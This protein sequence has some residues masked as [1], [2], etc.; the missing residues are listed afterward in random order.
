M[1]GCS[2]AVHASRTRDTS[3]LILL[4][5]Q[6]QCKQKGD[7]WAFRLLALVTMTGETLKGMIEMAKAKQRA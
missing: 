5:H 2:I 3:I 1:L 4:K 7:I 6:T